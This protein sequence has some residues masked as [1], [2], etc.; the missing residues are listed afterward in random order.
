[1]GLFARKVSSVKPDPVGT[2]PTR[3]PAAAKRKP[4]FARQRL[5]RRWLGLDIGSSAVKIVE[6]SHWGETYRV[7]AFAVEP[8]PAGSVVAGNISDVGAVGEAIRN[9]CKR[10]RVR[11]RKVCVGIENTAVVTKTL[12]MDASLTD[13]ELEADINAEAE[14]H[15][16][17]PID[18]V[19]ID[20]VPMHLSP[21]D[22][23]KV[24]VLL[25]VCRLE[26]V[27]RCQEAVELGGLR[28]DV[29][30][31]DGHAAHHAVEQITQ[32]RGSVV[33]ADVGACTTRVMLI[34][35]DATVV[36]DEQFDGSVLAGPDGG[37][38]DLLLGLLTRLVRLV[39]LTS[40][41][42]PLNRLL[43]AGGVGTLPGLADRIGERLALE[44]EVADT[45]RGMAVADQ[46]D[47]ESLRAS[48]PAL[49]TACGLSLRGLQ[50]E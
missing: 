31:V 34:G 46:V 42:P 30:E 20:F 21:A 39:C 36:R 7:E 25:V 4:G 28:L 19:A 49:L 16:P 18:E 38:V 44:V 5:R 45:F 12:E 22:P 23:S 50:E 15:I 24:V 17:F 43:L 10:A 29:V 13:R 33:L 8:V 35:G 48:A 26:H 6:L 9:A 41:E 3:V 14:R 1:M 27:A 40:P 11:P 2:Q 47:K 37:G 32:A